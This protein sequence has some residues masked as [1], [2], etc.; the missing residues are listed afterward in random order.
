MRSREPQHL[1]RPD[2]VRVGP[3]DVAVAFVQDAAWCGSARGLTRCRSQEA[4]Q[5]QPGR[6]FR[7]ASAASAA[8]LE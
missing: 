5:T 6:S 2:E 7:G 4:I 1:A 3:D 8:G